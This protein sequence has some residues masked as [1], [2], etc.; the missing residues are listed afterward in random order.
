MKIYQS[1]VFRSK[2]PAIDALRTVVEDN[3]GHR[4]TR[5]DL[6]KIEEN[7][8]PVVG[9]TAGW[10]FGKIRRP[11]NATLEAA[12]RALGYERK[13]QKMNGSAKK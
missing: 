13:W 4:V 12:G 7:G 9:T 10:F 2:D 11:T 3:V 6:K 8:G 1:Y 5:K